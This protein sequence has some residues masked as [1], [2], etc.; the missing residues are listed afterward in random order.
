MKSACVRH[1]ILGLVALLAAGPA[2]AAETKAKE[3][4]S[5]GMMRSA[6][7]DATRVQAQEWLKAAGKFDDASQKAFEAIWKSEDLTLLDK[8]ADTFCLGSPEAAKL[9]AEARDPSAPAPKELPA[10]LKDAK[11]NAFFR[12][13]LALAYSKALSQRRIYEE[14]LEALKGVK[15]EQV[16][17]PASYFFHKAVSEHAM[18]LRD[19]ANRS[20]ARLLDDCADA[21]ERYRMLAAMMYFEMAAWKEKLDLGHIGRLMNNVERRLDVGRGG[22]KTQKIEREVIARLDELIKQLE[23]Q[24]K[25]SGQGN[26][27]GC[28]SGGQPGGSSGSSPGN[29][30]QPSSPQQD[31][32]GG[33]NSGPGNVDMKELKNKIEAWGKLPEKERAQAM[34]DLIKS[35]PV[36]NRDKIEKYFKRVA[37]SGGD[38]K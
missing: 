37:Q 26:G 21:P 30:N 33:T 23:N 15:P 18:L 35:M 38:A 31:S 11:Q 32:V 10:V 13:N 14:S 17:D 19:D 24:Q 22:P 27:G 9:L 12:A 6:S 16:V 20:I 4:A 1:S 2:L 7:E 36:E 34:A 28:P 5:F 25:G 3:L 8:L 29:T